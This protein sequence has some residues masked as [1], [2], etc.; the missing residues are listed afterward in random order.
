M[1]TNY[2]P[3]WHFLTY[4][5]IYSLG[6]V[7]IKVKYTK[8]ELW[9]TGITIELDSNHSTEDLTKM[10]MDKL[11]GMLKLRNLSLLCKMYQQSNVV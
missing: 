2:W 11:K 6:P 7:E 3:S 9:I 4:R 1:N 5:N 10:A 8:N